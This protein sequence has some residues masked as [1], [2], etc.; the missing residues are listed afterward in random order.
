MAQFDDLSPGQEEV[1]AAEARMAARRAEGYA[2]HARYDRR[3]DRVVVRLNTGLE[4][5]F[6]P[7]QAQG[8]ENARSADL[9]EIEISPSGLG[10]HFP[11]LDADLY[12]PALMQG[13]SGSERWMAERTSER[14]DSERAVMTTKAA[15]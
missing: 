9:D 6:P 11:R 3:I 7:R 14:D 12:V 5:A 4:L 10:L 8:L 15:V 13:V 1:A 2:V